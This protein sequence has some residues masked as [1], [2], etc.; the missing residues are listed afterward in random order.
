MTMADYRTKLRR[1]IHEVEI[2]RRTNCL[3]Q[4]RPRLEVP[5]DLAVHNNKN[6]E[7][8]HDALM[9]LH[10]ALPFCRRTR[11]RELSP[12]RLPVCAPTQPPSCP[13]LRVCEILAVPVRKVIMLVSD[14][15]PTR[16]VV[17]EIDTNGG[18]NIC[19]GSVIR[20]SCVRSRGTLPGAAGRP[21]VGDSGAHL[22]TKGRSRQIKN[23]PV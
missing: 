23:R 20:A 11:P 8:R 7:F 4:R 3:E 21:R 22:N 1:T 5:N 12:A 2:V 9:F 16:K 17:C 15:S 6:T 18:D 10:C 13:E 19:H 14:R